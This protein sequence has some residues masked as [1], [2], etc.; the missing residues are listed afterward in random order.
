MA[1]FSRG[2]AAAFCLLLAGCVAGGK[3]PDAPAN[4]ITGDVIEVTALDAPAPAAAKPAA[5]PAAAPVPAAQETAA[6][7]A[8]VQ[9]TVAQE[10]AAE[11]A[12][13]APEAAPPV[14]EVQ[15]S[16]AQLACEKRKGVWSKTAAGLHGCVSFTKD[17]GKRCTRSGQCE[18][19]CLARSGTCAPYAPLF[20]CNEVLDDMGR[21]MTQCLQ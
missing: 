16:A 8:V 6:Q 14:P 5:G 17:S 9:E 1:G 2:V 13:P 18:S 19:Q 20:G 7:E 10:V 21:R 12:P 3:M 11:A 15:K 4:V